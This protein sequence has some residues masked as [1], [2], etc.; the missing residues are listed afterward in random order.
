MRK[1]YKNI[2]KINLVLRG[3][4]ERIRNLNPIRTK[5]YNKM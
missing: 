5:L 2:S 1:D 4:I 3:N